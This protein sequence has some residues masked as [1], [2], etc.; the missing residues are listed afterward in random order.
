MPA[1][2]FLANV[3]S[4]EFCKISKNTFSY[5]AP[6]VA[7]STPSRWHWKALRRF[8]LK[9][10][11]HILLVIIIIIFVCNNLFQETFPNVPFLARNFLTARFFLDT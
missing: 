4:C 10:I 3:F 6:P 9:Y 1:T 8:L 2:L 11:Y 7:A 5:T